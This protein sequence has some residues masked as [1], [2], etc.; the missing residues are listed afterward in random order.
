M[1]GVLDGRAGLAHLLELGVGR[2]LLGLA[3][4]PATSAWAPR[5]RAQA[6]TAAATSAEPGWS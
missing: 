6:A 3:S 4:L 2:R 5:P 1:G